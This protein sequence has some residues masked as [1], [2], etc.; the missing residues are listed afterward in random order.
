M[1]DS[2]YSNYSNAIS[3]FVIGYNKSI[4]LQSV[5]VSALSIISGNIDRVKNSLESIVAAFEEIRATSESS[6]NN[7]GDID[8]Q[9]QEIVKQNA[10]LNTN[11][12]KR[13]DE[14][15]AAGK[16]ITN[17]VKVFSML[18]E[19]SKRIYGMSAAIQ[20]VSDRTNVLAINA[21]IEA[22]R[23]GEHG[24]GFRIIANEVRKLALQTQDFA[25]E[26][27][28]TVNDFQGMI[29]EIS[30]D[31]YAFQKLI[32]EFEKD[33][34]NMKISFANTEGS[35]K[36]VGDSITMISQAVSEQT[37]ALNEG[38]KSLDSIYSS[39]RDTDIVAKTMGKT[40]VALSSLLNEKA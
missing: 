21:S 16:N 15:A 2:N 26:I 11:L 30:G 3:K 8:R 35:A 1:D 32:G 34:N 6:T 40:Y 18:V 14:I 7:V 23:A 29:D 25:K 4:V 24:K 12:I 38:L 5:T 27:E 28:K 39:I 22:A 9:M 19:N 33:I 37:L 10:D 31:I 13:V 36:Q 17:L 20:D